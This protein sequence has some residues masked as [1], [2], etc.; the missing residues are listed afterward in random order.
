MLNRSSAAVS[1]VCLSHLFL[2]QRMTWKPT[3]GAY[4]RPR[5]LVFLLFFILAVLS[6]WANGGEHAD[7]H[8]SQHGCRRARAVYTPKKA[9][10]ERS[11]TSTLEPRSFFL[12]LTEWMNFKHRTP[13]YLIMKH[14]AGFTAF[15]H[16]KESKPSASHGD[17]TKK[18]RSQKSWLS[19]SLVQIGLIK[20]HLRAHL[21]PDSDH[22]SVAQHHLADTCCC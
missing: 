16:L 13:V 4:T 3:F 8:Q 11:F 7:V 14:P 15:Y 9:E 17:R 19:F 12:F 21:R 22:G 1:R 10:R 5:M 20:A 6:C 18:P 2:S